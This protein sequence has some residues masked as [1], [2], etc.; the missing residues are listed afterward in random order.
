[1]NYQSR[2]LIKALVG[3]R[4]QRQGPVVFPGVEDGT[5]SP[6][7]RTPA[8]G[9]HK[10]AICQPEAG[11]KPA[12]AGHLS[13]YCNMLSAAGPRGAA[14]GQ[15]WAGTFS[16]RRGAR[17]SP[18]KHASGWIG[19][20]LAAGPVVDPGMGRL[21]SVSS[22]DCHD[23]AGNRA[24]G[25][26]VAGLHTGHD[27]ITPPAP[28]PSPHRPRAPARSQ[29]RASGRPGAVWAPHDDGE[30]ACEAGHGVY[31]TFQDRLGRQYFFARPQ[32]A[33]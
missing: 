20:G 26:G 19:G 6:T 3:V 2:E 30:S 31:S 23:C 25:R 15:D 5:M 33:C 24:P 14:V 10:C 9:Q 12:Q 1:M 18:G 32:G 16:N 28:A 29:A 8:I 17:L 4:G 11:R 22:A 21:V 7:G 13:P 27:P